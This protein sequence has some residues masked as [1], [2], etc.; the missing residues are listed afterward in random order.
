METCSSGEA[1]EDVGKK[2]GRMRG[3]I[4]SG[5]GGQA[6]ILGVLMMVVLVAITSLVIDIGFAWNEKADLQKSADAAALAGIYYLPEDTDAAYARAVEW[7]ERNGLAEGDYEIT[8]RSRNGPDDTIEVEVKGSTKAFFA[9]VLGFTAFDVRARAVAQVGSPAGLRNFV[10]FAVLQEELD[11]KETGDPTLIKYDSQDMQSGN[12]LLLDIPADP[13]C[14]WGSNDFRKTIICGSADA[15][16]AYGQ[17]YEGCS[18][19]M[20][21]QTGQA[22]GQVRDALKARLDL[23]SEECDEF[24]DVFLPSPDGASDVVLTDRCNPFPPHDAPDSKRVVILPVVEKLPSGSSEPV[25]IIRFAL[26]FI[27]ELDCP[28]GQGHCDLKGI[29][30]E[31][32]ANFG[33][34]EAVGAYDPTAPFIIR[35]LVE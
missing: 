21:T 5:E 11:G 35:R 26:F 1:P 4:K 30:V 33:G 12:S 17:E 19:T 14:P 13:D 25:T 24:D 28:G 31:N 15:F 23:T 9:R 2:E 10:P 18:S 22:I 7:A 34:Y 27:T 8:I 20:D 6:M 32:V 3:H 16:C 29:Y